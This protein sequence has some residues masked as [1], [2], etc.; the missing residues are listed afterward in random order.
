MSI[1]PDHTLLTIGTNPSPGGELTV[2]FSGEGTPVPRHKI[3]PLS[4]EY[5]LIHT[6]LHGKGVFECAGKLHH[7]QAGDTFVILPGVTFSYEADAHN[8]WHYIWLA[9]LDQ[10]PGMMMA[11]MGITPT[12]PIIHCANPNQ[13]TELTMLYRHIRQCFKQS[14][15]PWLEDL[16]SSGWARLLLHQL[17]MLNKEF[18]PPST[19]D[20]PDIEKG[21]REAERWISTHYHQQLSIDHMAKTLG[22]HRAH[23]SKM[24]KQFTGLSPMQYLIKVRIEKAR[25]LLKTSITIHEIASSVGFNDALYFS[26]QFRKRYGMTPS[27]YRSKLEKG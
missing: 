13:L 26:K 23:L 12:H 9:L 16:E 8:P 15:Q 5:V 22:Y 10:E 14:N 3:G 7:L 4:R 11:D 17:A 1:S 18:L 2:L 20:I 21:V 25:Q 19:Q 27:E 24:F 6:V